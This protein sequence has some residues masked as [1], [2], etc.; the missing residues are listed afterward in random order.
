MTITSNRTAAEHY[1]H[2]WSNVAAHP[3]ACSSPIT[4]TVARASG[5][6][7]RLMNGG[8]CGILNASGRE[9][10]LCNVP[11]LPCHS[12]DMDFDVC[13]CVTPFFRVSEY[14]PPHT[15]T[16]TRPRPRPAEETTPSSALKRIRP[17]LIKIRTASVFL[18]KIICCVSKYLH[19][20]ICSLLAYIG[21]SAWTDTGIAFGPFSS[22]LN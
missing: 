15:S 6:Y 8:V 13:V 16:S 12:I 1:L 3:G 7:N 21:H 9:V 22:H 14:Q 17:E 18:I 2:K 11:F 4:V 19:L 20:R 10:S 5:D